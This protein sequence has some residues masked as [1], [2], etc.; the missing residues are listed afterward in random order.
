MMEHHA[1]ELEKATRDIK[2]CVNQYLKTQ[3]ATY[4]AEIYFQ[5]EWIDKLQEKLKNDI[6]SKWAERK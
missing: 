1:K 6:R 5:L 2:I 3:D 4:I